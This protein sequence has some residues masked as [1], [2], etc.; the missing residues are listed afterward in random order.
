MLALG[1]FIKYLKFERHYSDHT[2][3]SYKRDLEQYALYLLTHLDLDNPS[4]A[5]HIHVRS[6]LVHLMQSNYKAKSVNRKL[7]TLKSYYKYLKKMGHIK[8]NPSSKISGPKLPK[9]LPTVIR[10]DNL[11]NG[12]NDHELEGQDSCDFNTLRD[13][14]IIQLLY[15]TGMRRSELINLKDQDINSERMEI[16]VLGKGNKERLI[17][18]TQEL[19]DRIR[20]YQAARD[21]NYEEINDVLLITDKGRPLYP[22][23]VYNKVKRWL[24]RISTN[25]KLSPHILRHSFATHMANRGAELNAIKELLG[26]ASLAATEVYMHN[27]VERLKEVYASAHPRTQKKR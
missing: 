12:L 19:A 10:E 24:S 26:H 2:V 8:V 1:S 27:S 15:Q 5:L 23:Y 17:P 9:R 3:A 22:K 11:Q 14:L 7:S 13:L 18:I 4:E 25:E 20:V 6:W 16:K 21:E